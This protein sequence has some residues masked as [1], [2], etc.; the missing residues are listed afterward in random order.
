[1]VHLLWYDLLTI[2]DRF[3]TSFKCSMQ[4]A[5]IDLEAMEMYRENITTAATN[6]VC[7]NLISVIVDS[8]PGF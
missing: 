3:K 7:S 5:E 6:K 1:M 4:L 8:V 2:H